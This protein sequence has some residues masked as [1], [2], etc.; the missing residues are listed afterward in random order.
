ML[1]E[2]AVQTP[3]SNCDSSASLMALTAP[4]SLN[5]PLG[6]RFSSFRYTSFPRDSESSRFSRT[7]GARSVTSPNTF[8]RGSHVLYGHSLQAAY[9]SH[10]QL[11][12]VF[13]TPSKA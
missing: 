8:L 9:G 7:S 12:G 13:A 1:P 3:R 4:R 10:S 11:S 6:W 2:L 5:A